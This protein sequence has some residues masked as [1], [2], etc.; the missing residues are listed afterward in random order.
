MAE[1]AVE[2]FKEKLGQWEGEKLHV[3]VREM[4]GKWTIIVHVERAIAHR[5]RPKEK[6]QHTERTGT[7]SE[8]EKSDGEPTGSPYRLVFIMIKTLTHSLLRSMNA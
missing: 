5:R 6:R 3:P 8:S 4:V 1:S 2:S 7:A